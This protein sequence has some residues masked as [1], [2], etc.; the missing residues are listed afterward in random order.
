MSDTLTFESM[1]PLTV[2]RFAV[3]VWRDVVNMNDSG[4]W[5]N[6]DLENIAIS[7]TDWC[8]SPVVIAR[9]ICKLERVAAVE[10]LDANRAGL[11]AYK[12]WP[13]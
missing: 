6:G 12:N 9:E 7:L 8:D 1:T 13:Q 10:V 2:G 11:V 4:E 3:R 5:D